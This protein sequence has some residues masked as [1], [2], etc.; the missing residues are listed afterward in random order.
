MK[1]RVTASSVFAPGLV[2]RARQ[3]RTRNSCPPALDKTS[4][5]KRHSLPKL[6]KSSVP[7]SPN[8]YHVEHWPLEDEIGKHK[9]NSSRAQRKLA[10]TSVFHSLSN[11]GSA[12]HSGHAPA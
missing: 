6:P 7:I 3:S 10:A 9:R 11:F 4:A 2:R 12:P 8:I 5:E 1:T